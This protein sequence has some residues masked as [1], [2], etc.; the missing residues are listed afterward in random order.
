MKKIRRSRAA[1][2]LAGLGMMAAIV[3]G[4]RPGEAA[5]AAPAQAQST[6]PSGSGAGTSSGWHHFY[7]H[8]TA[9]SPPSFQALEKEMCDLINRDRSDPINRAETGGRLVPLRWNDE[10]AAAARAHSRDMVARGYFG[11]VD[12][13]G[14]SPGA[15]LKA[16]GISWRA[17]GENIAMDPDVK[18]AETAFMNEPRSG[19]NHRSNILSPKFTDVGVGI[20]A[21]PDGELYITQEFMAPAISLQSAFGPPSK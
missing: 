17:V 16:A 5:V 7:Q 19:Q 13:E 12:P 14:R 11:H 9:A 15:R 1:A 10:L 6:A 21:G 8:K 18:A 3:A 2:I 20:V 4:H